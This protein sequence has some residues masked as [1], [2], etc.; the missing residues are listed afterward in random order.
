MCRSLPQCTKPAPH[1]FKPLLC[2]SVGATVLQCNA[3]AYLWSYL[4]Y[5]APD[6]HW[7]LDFRYLPMSAKHSHT[8]QCN[9]NE[10][11][12]PSCHTIKKYDERTLHLCLFLPIRTVSLLFLHQGLKMKYWH[13]IHPALEIPSVAGCSL[14]RI[15]LLQQHTAAWQG[16]QL[17]IKRP[18]I[19]CPLLRI[20]FT[21]P[22]TSFCLIVISPLLP[23]DNF[24]ERESTPVSCPSCSSSQLQL[25]IAWLSSGA[26]SIL[27][28]N[29]AATNPWLASSSSP[30]AFASLTG[31]VAQ[32]LV[33]WLIWLG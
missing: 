2:F 21:C 14:S 32:C 24:W 26:S 8:V 17:T 13:H 4:H 29:A 6:L 31:D 11:V 10:H 20:F 33:A 25:N 27:C 22:C 30:A 3:K 28:Q 19:L 1:T 12:Q 16:S 15:A 5:S 7:H 23:E 18:D 9:T